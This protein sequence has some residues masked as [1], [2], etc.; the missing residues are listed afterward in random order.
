MNR[1]ERRQLERQQRKS[2]K[3]IEVNVAHTL[4]QAIQHAEKSG[5]EF[6]GYDGIFYL[7]VLGKWTSNDII[8]ELLVFP[9]YRKIYEKYSKMPEVGEMMAK[10]LLITVFSTNFGNG[11]EYDIVSQIL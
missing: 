5:V 7:K 6:F 2:Q 1:S 3:S 4:E 8:P 10:D 11:S 9:Q